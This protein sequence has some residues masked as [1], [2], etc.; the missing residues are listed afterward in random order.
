[1][2]L[3]KVFV[4]GVVVIGLVTAFGIHATGLAKVGKVG[5]KGSQG[6]LHTAERG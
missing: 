5:F 3:L 4:S 6:L 1:M 2:E